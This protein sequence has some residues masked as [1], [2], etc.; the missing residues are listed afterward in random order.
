MPDDIPDRMSINSWNDDRIGEVDYH[1]HRS[2]FAEFRRRFAAV[3]FGMFQKKPLC[4][5][6]PK[7][8]LM[9]IDS[10]LIR[11]QLG[12]QADG[13]TT[14]LTFGEGT[15]LTLFECSTTRQMLYLNPDV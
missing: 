2:L 6:E 3:L 15:L 4:D 13:T 7:Q 1:N 5:R 14:R 12:D 8:N 10:V 11:K 9:G